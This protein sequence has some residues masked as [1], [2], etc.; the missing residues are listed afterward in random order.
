MKGI[1]LPINVMVI[2]ALAVIVLFAVL[3]IF[4]GVWAPLGQTVTPKAALDA[5]C[6][7]LVTMGCETNLAEIYVTNFDADGNGKTGDKADNL[8]VLCASKTFNKDE[9]GCRTVC[10]CT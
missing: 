5:A 7:K 1:E 6:L 10:G 4:M 2:L 3:M 8:K 9:D